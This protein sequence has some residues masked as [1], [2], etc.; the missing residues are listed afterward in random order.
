MDDCLRVPK[1]SGIVKKK[2]QY[3]WEPPSVIFCSLE[4]LGVPIV[5]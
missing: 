3:K 2:V 5:D 4:C 1:G